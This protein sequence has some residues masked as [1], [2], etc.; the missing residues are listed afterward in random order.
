MRESNA[1]LWHIAGRHVD[2]VETVSD[3]DL[4]EVDG[5]IIRVGESDLPEDT[6]ESMAKLHGFA[7]GETSGVGIHV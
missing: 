1:E 6:V 3:V 4:Q 7:G 2:T 5:T